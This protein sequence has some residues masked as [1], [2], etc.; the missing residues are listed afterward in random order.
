[1]CPNGL[2][3]PVLNTYEPQNLSKK[4]QKY[5]FSQT[6]NFYILKGSKFF[7]F[8]TA[9]LVGAHIS[10]VYPGEINQYEA[11]M[12]EEYGQIIEFIP[13]SCEIVYP[14]KWKGIDA[15]YLVIVE[16]L[17]LNNLREK[18]GLSPLEHAF[19]ITIGVKF[20]KHELDFLSSD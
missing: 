10:V 9:P 17:Q 11:K 18:Y 5:I 16:A 3:F 19:H 14:I 8:S 6:R 20:S 12:I 2:N 4:I 15:A 7:W 1:M 13:Q